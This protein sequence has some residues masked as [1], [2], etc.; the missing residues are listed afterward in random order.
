MHRYILLAVYCLTLFSSAWPSLSAANTTTTEPSSPAYDPELR[1]SLEQALAAPNSSFHNR[2]VAEVWLLDM[3]NRLAPFVAKQ[4]ERIALL[5]LIHSEAQRAELA[6]ELV[7]AIIHVESYFQPV[8]SSSAGAQGLMQIMPF[9]K[10]EIGRGSD[11]LFD[12][13]TNLRYGCT[14]FRHYLDR[15]KGNIDRALQRYNG[16]VGGTAYSERV[17]RVLYRHWYRQ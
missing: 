15:E 14:I 2:F 12:P 4:S 9:W 3:A 13:A 10:R 7:L 17:K 16:A 8:A 5:Q 11:D 1:L 6:P